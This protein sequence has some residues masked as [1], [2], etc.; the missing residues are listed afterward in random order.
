MS[1]S[2]TVCAL[3]IGLTAVMLC[4]GCAGKE[5]AEKAPVTAKADGGL[6]ALDDLP[7]LDDLTLKHPMGGGVAATTTV[8]GEEYARR[9]VMLDGTAGMKSGEVGAGRRVEFVPR[10]PE[11]KEWRPVLERKPPAP[12]QLLPKLVIPSLSEK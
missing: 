10:S 5:A 8:M 4:G 3:F 9:E 6:I 11:V 12:D 7:T 1:R 2:K